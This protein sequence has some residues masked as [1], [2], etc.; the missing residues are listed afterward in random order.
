MATLA[1][2]LVVAV[3]IAGLFIYQPKDN[4]TSG[5]TTS[6]PLPELLIEEGIALNGLYVNGPSEQTILSIIEP[7]GG[8]VIDT[9]E[10]GNLPVYT[11]VFE[12]ERSLDRMMEI[13]DEIR[14]TKGMSAD[15]I[16]LASTSDQN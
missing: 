16:V 10:V 6:D 11:V 13:R 3:I 5:V 2:A 12:G 4:E 1:L 7:L 8:V 9:D 15:L 14:S